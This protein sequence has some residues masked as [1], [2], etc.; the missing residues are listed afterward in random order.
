MH[1]ECSQ[2]DLQ[3][4]FP[5]AR[6]GCEVAS[7]AVGVKFRRLPLDHVEMRYVDVWCVVSRRLGLYYQL[8][9]VRIARCSSRIARLRTTAVTASVL[10]RRRKTNVAGPVHLTDIRQSLTCFRLQSFDSRPRTSVG[11]APNRSE[12][13]RLKCAPL[14]NPVLRAISSNERVECSSISCAART[15]TDM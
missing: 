2:R 4:R 12:I 14:E 8:A 10:I 13:V 15:R 7:R 1:C 5:S 9:F 11:V 6:T 3:T